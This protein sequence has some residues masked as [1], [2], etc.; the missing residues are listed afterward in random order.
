MIYIMLVFCAEIYFLMKLNSILDTKIKH[1][2]TGL[3]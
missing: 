1:K 2:L 3:N